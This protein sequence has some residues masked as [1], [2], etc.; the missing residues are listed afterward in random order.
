MN[1]QP[2]DD[3]KVQ[4]S[5]V[6]IN[7]ISQNSLEW[8]KA[9]Q[10]PARASVRDS[11]EFQ[12]LQPQATLAEQIPNLNFVPPVPGIGDV[13]VFGSPHAMRIWLKPE[14]MAALGISPSQARDALAQ[15]NYLSAL[16]STKGSMTCCGIRWA[17]WSSSTP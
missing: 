14:R 8:A 3:N 1:Q 7:W 10:I 12:N 13:N 9:G 2:L 6:F 5:K 4:A 11:Q 17:A 15:N 16:G